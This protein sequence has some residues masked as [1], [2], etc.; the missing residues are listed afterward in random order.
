[1]AEITYLLTAA[2]TFSSRDND[3][4]QK[5]V[6]IDVYARL[7]DFVP[8]RQIATGLGTTNTETGELA[9]H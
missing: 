7:E 2:T 8:G 5:Y 3:L 9:H 4:T 6:M 1:M